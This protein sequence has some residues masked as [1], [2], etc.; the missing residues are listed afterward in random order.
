M[1]HI[2]PLESIPPEF[3]P[4]FRTSIRESMEADYAIITPTDKKELVLMQLEDLG[5]YNEK[6]YNDPTKNFTQYWI[7]DINEAGLKDYFLQKICRRDLTN[8]VKEICVIAVKVPHNIIAEFSEKEKIDVPLKASN[9]DLVIYVPYEKDKS[10]L[11][12]NFLE[13]EK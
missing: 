9:T 7:T 2:Q 10:R 4:Y 1:E 12:I 6:E 13:T 11:Y 5:L 8:K 3:E